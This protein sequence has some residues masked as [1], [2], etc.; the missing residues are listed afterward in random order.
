VVA[1]NLVF[2]NK[3]HGISIGT[4]T[5]NTNGNDGDNFIV[6]NN[7]IIYYDYDGKLR[8]GSIDIGPFQP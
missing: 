3:Q 8:Q 5:D 4:N 2:N 1:N 7:I 6:A